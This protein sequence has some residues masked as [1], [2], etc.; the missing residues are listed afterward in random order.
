MKL[1]R[2]VGAAAVLLLLAV[3][4]GALAAGGEEGRHFAGGVA[5]DQGVVVEVVFVR[6]VCRVHRGR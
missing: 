2:M 4:T 5:F 1:K 6:R 3:C